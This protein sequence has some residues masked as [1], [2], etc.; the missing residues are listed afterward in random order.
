M[1][2]TT[3][4][5]MGVAVPALFGGT[6]TRPTWRR[7]GGPVAG[8]DPEV[9]S[10]RG[11]DS[12]SSFS[13]SGCRFFPL[14]KRFRP[15]LRHAA[16]VPTPFIHV[17]AFQMGMGGAPLAQ[18]HKGTQA[19]CFEKF[20]VVRSYCAYPRSEIEPGFGQRTL[21]QIIEAV[22]LPERRAETEKAVV[23][24][25][26]AL[27]SRVALKKTLILSFFGDGCFQHAASLF[28][29]RRPFRI[30]LFNPDDFLGRQSFRAYFTVSSLVSVKP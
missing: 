20:S 8:R 26:K 23:A 17:A 11:L 25:G 10:L 13:G 9:V 6:Q 18:I 3:S 19:A 7:P 4:R 29:G 24:Y 16:E 21:A 27:S 22:A 15:C 28:H 5:F 1:S 2:E 14:P 30:C 12:F